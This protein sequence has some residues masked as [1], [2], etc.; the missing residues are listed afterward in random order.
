MTTIFRFPAGFLWGAATASHQVEGDNRAN[1]WWELEQAGQL[2]Y[3]SG[4]ACRHYELYESDFDL[5]RSCAH[6]AHRLSLEWS[7][8]EPERGEFNERAL[9]HYAQVIAALRARGIEPLVTLHHFTN[10]LWF[11]R[12]GAWT[13]QISVELFTRYVERVLSRLGNDVRYWVTINE[14]TV[15]VM[16]AFVQGDWPPRRPRSLR[17]AGLALRNMCR[18]HSAV[19]PLIHAHRPDAMVGFAHSAPYIVPREASRP[20]DRFAARMRNFV[21][22]ELV[23]RLLGRDPRRVLDFIGINYYVR[24]VVQWE[25]RGLKAV[26]GSEYKAPAATGERR[27]SELGWEI[28]PAGLEAMLGRFAAYGLPL[29][30]TENGVATL[31]EPLRADF[32]RAHVR[33]LA[34]AMR[35]GVDVLGYFYWTLFDNF[36]WTEGFNAHFGL[37]AVDPATQ[38]RRLR[39]GAAP[40]RQI[41]AANEINIDA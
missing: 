14:P 2:P 13:A 3:R 41:C 28:H 16:R 35:R 21:L 39:A 24:Q 7:R 10:P 32:I 17:R 12:L 22:N 33:A 1:D 11:A 40:F 6:N 26:F 18:A 4:A 19:Y 23:F 36:E 20:L 34:R 15:Y 8:I 29:I 37:A 9:D 30:V 5:A 25:P 31:D 27:F 38:A